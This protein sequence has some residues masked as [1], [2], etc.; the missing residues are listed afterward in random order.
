MTYQTPSPS[1]TSDL[2]AANARIAAARRDGMASA[3]HASAAPMRNRHDS[4][5]SQ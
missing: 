2:P 5:V 1:A 4:S 3:I